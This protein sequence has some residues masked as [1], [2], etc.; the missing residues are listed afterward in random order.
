MVEW[1]AHKFRVKVSCNTRL[2]QTLNCFIFGN[3]ATWILFDV[4]IWPKRA[5]RIYIMRV[6]DV[7]DANQVEDYFAKVHGI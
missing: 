1:N 5:P 6:I 7:L 2:F 3:L 4:T